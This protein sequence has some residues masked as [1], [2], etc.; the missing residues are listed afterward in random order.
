M[1]KIVKNALILMA[2]TLVSGICL[3]FVYDITKGPIEQQEALAQEEAYKAVFPDMAAMEPLYD[4]SD[5]MNA[6]KGKAAQVLAENGLEAVHIEEAYRAVDSEQTVLGVVMNLTTTEGYGGD[7]NF[8]MGI[9]NDGTVNGI[10][11]LTIG[12]TAGLGMKATEED[13]RGQFAGKKAESF[14]VTKTGA[15]EDNQI[16]AISGATIT[17]NAMT[18][19]VNAGLC[20]F[21]SLQK[22][23]GV[24]GE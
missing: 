10:E 13:F 12:E 16:D 5:D 4:G 22:E 15:S 8:S 9:Q 2:I 11:I 24:L 19:G 20:F 1:N 3:G 21:Q 7:I 6:V 14:E 17:S 23:G 18:K